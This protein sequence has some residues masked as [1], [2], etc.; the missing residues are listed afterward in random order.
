MYL[1]ISISQGIA[2][3]NMNAVWSGKL[4]CLSVYSPFQSFS[5]NHLCDTCAVLFCSF[6]FSRGNVLA[7][8]F[9][10]T[11]AMFF[12]QSCYRDM[13]CCVSEKFSPHLLKQAKYISQW[14]L[15]K[16]STLT[17]T[18]YFFTSRKKQKLFLAGSTILI[19]RVNAPFFSAKASE[20]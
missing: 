4:S 20:I 1:H 14:Q 3:S 18:C 17:V 2:F 12:Q 6:F 5:P 13:V 7:H 10:H 15:N 8:H 16:T 9:F 19:D 11:G